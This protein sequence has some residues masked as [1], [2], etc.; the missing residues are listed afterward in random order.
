[1]AGA[2]IQGTL[3][4]QGLIGTSIQGTTGTSIQG[5]T[6]ESIQGTI[7]TSIQGTLGNQGIQGL[8]GLQGTQGA[9]IQ[10]IQGTQGTQ[11]G[12]G[13][14]GTLGIQGNIGIQGTGFEEASNVV[15]N[16]VYGNLYN[17]YA[18]TDAKNIAPV[19]WHVPT[20]TE[21]T[22]LENYLITNGYNYDGTTSGN[23]IAKSLAT[24]TGWTSNSGTGTV[25]NSDYPAYQ[26]KTGFLTFPNGIR[27]T[28]GGFFNINSISYW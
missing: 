25:G 18:V 11:G 24:S 4:S 13:S 14:Q 6:G 5:T 17:W 16:I 23:K 19:G 8:L 26:N 3:G 10:G 15:T 27:A 22:T 7:G 28:E 2:S 9:S 1:L 21:L 12:L 20:D